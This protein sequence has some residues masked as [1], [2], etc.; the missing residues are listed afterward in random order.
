M[1]RCRF[2]FFWLLTFFSISIS[3]SMFAG[4][5]FAGAVS[6]DAD[7]V[8]DTASQDK[9]I[10]I[11]SL[12]S[13]FSVL[14]E[15]N[16]RYQYTSLLTY[17]ANGYITTFKLNHRVDNNVV[18]QQLVFMDGPQRQVFRQQGLSRC[19]LEQVGWGLWPAALSNSPLNTYS[20]RAIGYERV[21]NRKAVIFDILPKDE[22][23]Y[24]YRYSIDQETGLVLKVMTF[25]KDAIVERFQTVS[26]NFINEGSD[27]T[28]D[29][30]TA[31]TLRV[32]EVDPCH[33]EQFQSAWQVGWLPEGFAAVGNR[34]TT[35][36]EQVLIFADGLVSV[37]I[38]IINNNE[39]PL[40]KASA[41]HGATA[42]VVAPV[43]FNGSKRG[44]GRSI[45]VVGEIPVATARRIAVS[46]KPQ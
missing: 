2:V 13:F 17:E 3:L 31:Y 15:A 38:F 16:K 28:F 5:V 37:S 4:A 19:G 22:L 18:Y 44:V 9:D 8:A 7:L 41:H 14:S 11:D 29:E 6:T 12:P 46:V 26:L 35:K 42:A 27:L 36:G 45:A 40:S 34:V 43:P 23:R 24:G 20:F 25:Y 32:P 30:S 10:V 1:P 33:T 39:V 21:A